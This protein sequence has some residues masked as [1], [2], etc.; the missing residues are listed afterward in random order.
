[1]D[2]AL[3]F[4]IFMIKKFLFFSLNDDYSNIFK[5]EGPPSSLSFPLSPSLSLSLPP[6]LSLYSSLSL[7]FSLD[8]LVKSRDTGTEI[9]YEINLPKTF[10]KWLFLTIFKCQILSL[11]FCSFWKGN[12]YMK[13]IM[14]ILDILTFCECLLS[15]YMLSA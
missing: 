10:C 6:S 12:T 7:Y 3:F 2:S 11:E 13:L 8:C 4:P 14:L 1:M 15:Y 9:W 5:C